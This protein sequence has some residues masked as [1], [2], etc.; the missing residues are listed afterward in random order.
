M[1]AVT[2]LDVEVEC[3]AAAASY[4]ESIIATLHLIRLSLVVRFE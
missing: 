3:V 4:G 2:G 1:C